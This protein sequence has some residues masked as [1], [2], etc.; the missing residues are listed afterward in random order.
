MK[1]TPIYTPESFCA[2]PFGSDSGDHAI[3]FQMLVKSL[4]VQDENRQY[5]IETAINFL[6][7]LRLSGIVEELSQGIVPKVI[8][9]KPWTRDQV[10]LGVAALLTCENYAQ[11]N[12]R[13][14][15]LPQGNESPEEIYISLSVAIVFLWGLR[16]YGRH[17]AFAAAVPNNTTPLLLTNPKKKKK[18]SA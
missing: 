1:L 2:V 14:H 13:K 12:L 15:L 3:C 7:D 10:K 9:P 16:D 18:G 17:Q 5:C 4:Q 6:V 8:Q 11:Q